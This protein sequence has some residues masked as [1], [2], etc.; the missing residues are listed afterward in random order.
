MF[1]KGFLL[2][3]FP[4]CIISCKSVSKEG[5]TIE[6]IEKN[7][8]K[9]LFSADS[10]YRFIEEQIAFGPRIPNT[11]AQKKCA[12]YLSNK[13]KQYGA[14]VIIQTTKLPIYNGQIVP[15]YNII[16]SFNPNIKRRLLLCAHWDT[17]P[18]SDRADKN[19]NTP[20]L[21][22]DDGA[23]GVAVLIEIARQIQIKQPNLGIDIIFFDLEDYGPPA[24]EETKYTGGD[25]Y[26]LGTQY[27]CKNP[28]IPNYSASNGILLDMVG[29]KNATFTYEGVSMQYAP[30][31]MKQIWNNAA[32]LGYGKYFVK[33]ISN[34][35][36]DDHYYINTLTTTPTIDIIFRTFETES[37]FAKHWHTHDDTIDNIDKNTLQAV[38]ETVLATIYNY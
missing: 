21:G 30:D 32:S 28:H 38:G 36:I 6:T 19:Q 10:T 24:S 15:C 16:G 34:P 31:F 13:L 12:D 33:R 3:L 2:F 7:I 29:A 23:S 35:I 17:R 22:V 25:F 4:L 11:P 14:E 18:F 20:N 37:G 8:E 9:P 1:K 5:N 26:A 27:W